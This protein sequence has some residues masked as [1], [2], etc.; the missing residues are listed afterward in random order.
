MSGM[1]IKMKGN[2]GTSGE[3]KM[4]LKN[5]DKRKVKVCFFIFFTSVFNGKM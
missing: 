4:S 5:V 1:R 3:L 2:I